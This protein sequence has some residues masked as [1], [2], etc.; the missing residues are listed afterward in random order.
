MVA[1][2]VGFLAFHI[3]EKLTILHYTHEDAYAKHTHPL[4]GVLSAL[5][6]MG[7]SF[8]DGIGIGLGFQVSPE[9]VWL[10]RNDTELNEINI[11]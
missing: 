10:F 1:F 4:V 7:H 5:A 11:L 2:V 8:A 9:R 6:L 3:V